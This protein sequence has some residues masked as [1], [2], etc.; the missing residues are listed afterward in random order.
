MVSSAQMSVVSNLQQH[1]WQ[2]LLQLTA[3]SKHQGQCRAQLEA[4]PCF[5]AVPTQ[6]E[7]WEETQ[8]CSSPC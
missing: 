1:P 5:T 8:S 4:Q 7:I 2:L 6:D 3:Q